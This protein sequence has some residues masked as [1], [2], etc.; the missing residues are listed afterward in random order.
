MISI[1]TSFLAIFRQFYPPAPPAFTEKDVKPGSQVGRVFIITGAN[2]GIGLE[3]VQVLYPTGAT[4]YLAGRSPSKIQATI[5]RVTSD[6]PPTETPA[7]LKSLY[8][9]LSDLTT[10]KRA[11]SQF[12][13]Q[14]TRLD[15][16]WNNAGNG[17]C[18]GSTTKQGLE[19]SVGTN[20]VAPL[21]FTQELVPLLQA[22]AKT[23][24]R[25]TVRIVWTGSVQIDVN[26]PHGGIDYERIKKPTTVTLEEYGASKAGNWFLA[27]EGAKR[28]GKYGIISVCENPGNLYTGIYATQSWL[29]MLFLRTFVLYKAR[30]GA[31]TMLFAGFSP[32][33]NEGNNGAYIWPWGNIQPIARP[34]V[35]QAASEGK[36]TKFWE[37]C[38]ESWKQYV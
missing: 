3:L 37:W 30:Y 17:Y 19:A 23:A 38:E 7:K 8:L 25:N 5:A 9:D 32:E 20:C 29:Y 18:P 27:V 28:W 14:E 2:S 16:L 34:D 22:A 33:I 10:I 31:Y 26:A 12:A 35:L 13:A 1:A 36:A 24:P 6:S 15:I 11:T 4:I 21:L